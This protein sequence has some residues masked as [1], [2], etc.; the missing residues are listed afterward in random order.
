MEEWT[1]GVKDV[2]EKMSE[3]FSLRTPKGRYLMVIIVCI[4]LLAL[5]WPAARSRSQGAGGITKASGLETGSSVKLQLAAELEN[6]LSQVQG[7]GKVDVALTV[8]SD[9]VKD[10]AVNSKDDKRETVEKDSKGVQSTVTEQ[11]TEKDLAVS[12]GGP[13][14]VEQKAPEIMGVLVV[15]DGA[16]DP[17]IKEELTDVTAALLNLSPYQVRVVARQITTEGGAGK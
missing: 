4:G 13:L 8:A 5:L 7:A 11:S 14:L 10:Y 16:R 15:A 17:A 12:G 1:R 2:K 6:I 9:G 3:K